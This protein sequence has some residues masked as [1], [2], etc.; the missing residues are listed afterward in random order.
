M[1]QFTPQLKEFLRLSVGYNLIPV[2]YEMIADTETP[3]SSFMKLD[4][5]EEAFL[6]ES[7]EAGERW[8][9]YSF[10]GVEPRAIIRGKNGAVEIIEAGEVRVEYQD[11][12]TVIRN[13]MKRFRPAVLPDMPRFFGGAI[14]YLS[15]DMVRYIEELPDLA[16]KDLDIHDFSFMITDTL[17]VFDNVD[18]TVKIICNAFIEDGKAPE[19]VYR[20]ATEKIKELVR[21]LKEGSLK[22]EEDGRK[23]VV[24]VSSNFRK[25]DF[26][27]A[28]ERVKEYIR[29]GDVIQTVISQRFETEKRAPSFDIYRAL[30]ITNPSPYMFFLRTSGIELAGSSPE[31][32]VRVEDGKVTVRPI[33]GTRRRGKDEEEDKRL[34]EE[35]LSDPKERAEHVML[36]DLGRNDVGRVSEAGT[37]RVNEFMVVERYSQVMHIVSNVEGTLKDGL[38]SIDALKACFPAGT[39][40][41]A[42]KIRA[43]EI[44][45]EIE[46]HK[47]G[48]YGGAVGY[49][50]FQGNMDM[51]ITIRTVLVKDK[52]IYVQAGAGVVADSVPEKEYEET[53]N[54]AKAVLKA[55]ELATEGLD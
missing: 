7:V 38:D 40:T 45:E 48:V 46:P 27:K 55:V 13:Y 36:V 25:E 17:V 39:L 23:D 22:K 14:G 30:R 42:P 1:K 34:E 43:M 47:R 9:R 24:P 6:L 54:K 11:P 18:H 51:C 44:I 37:V 29:A 28:V 31:I 16:R 3:V 20:E 2:C 19:D 41:G 26:L 15:Y 21:R 53:V 50:G 52:A 4:S 32:L 35:L 8:G 10:I 33:A 12:F 49:I 5:N